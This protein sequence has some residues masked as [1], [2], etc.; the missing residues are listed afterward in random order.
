MRIILFLFL[1]GLVGTVTAFAKCVQGNCVNGEG[2]YHY[3]NGK[4]YIGGYKDGMHHGQGTYLYPD[5]SKYVG[6]FQ[7]RRYHGKGAYTYADG[8]VYTGEF[9]QGLMHGQGILTSK[10]GWFKKELGITANFLNKKLF[11]YNL[12]F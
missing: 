9:K 6:E 10:M 4:K 8:T 5:G 3:A 7:Y 11:E 12:V 1:L 2:T